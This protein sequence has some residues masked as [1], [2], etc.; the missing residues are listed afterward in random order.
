[1]NVNLAEKLVTEF[2]QGKLSRRQLAQRLCGVQRQVSASSILVA[3]VM[4]RPSP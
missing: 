2:E 3:V 4:S 1:M